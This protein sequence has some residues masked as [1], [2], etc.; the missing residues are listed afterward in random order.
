MFLLLFRALLPSPKHSIFL[1]PKTPLT[2]AQRVPE[3]S[4]AG[5]GD[6]GDRAHFP[7]VAASTAPSTELFMA[8]NCQCVGLQRP[9]PPAK[10]GKRRG[11]RRG[12]ESTWEFPSPTAHAVC[13]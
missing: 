13:G 10:A 5:V 2:G 8:K 9:H 4:N 1:Q 6:K 12:M 7:G 11:E 3:A